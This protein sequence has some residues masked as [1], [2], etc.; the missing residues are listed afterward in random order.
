MTIMWDYNAWTLRRIHQIQDVHGI[1][2]TVFSRCGLASMFGSQASTSQ[3][4]TSQA[5]TSQA[6]TSQASTS[7]PPPH[8][9]C[10]TVPASRCLLFQYRLSRYRLLRCLLSRCLLFQYRLS[11]WRH[12]QCRLS[13][14]FN[15][16]G[17]RLW[18]LEDRL[19]SLAIHHFLIPS[20]M[21]GIRVKHF[22]SLVEYW[23]ASVPK[24]NFWAYHKLE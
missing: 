12:L 19:W 22:A 21:L 2:G 9:A 11:G 5:S 18:F 6:S 16:A 17:V 4:S 20:V 8:G 13:G 10:F 15:F 3:A 1:H 7:H 14:F 23:L 24:S